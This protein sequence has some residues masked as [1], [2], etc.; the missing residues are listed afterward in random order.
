MTFTRTVP[1]GINR[2]CQKFYSANLFDLREFQRFY[3][4]S[5]NNRPIMY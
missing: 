3:S 1:P 2:V 4:L 5:E